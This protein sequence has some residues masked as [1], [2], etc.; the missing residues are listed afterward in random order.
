MDNN[1]ANNEQKQ[2][3]PT[4][5]LGID[6]AI[7]LS[8]T[9][10]DKS[11]LSNKRDV[12]Y[13]LACYGCMFD[14]IYAT[15]PDPILKKYHCF[16]MPEPNKLDLYE[17]AYTMVTLSDDTE[18]KKSWFI[19]FAYVIISNAPHDPE[20]FDKLREILHTEEVFKAVLQSRYSVYILPTQEE[21]AAQG[22][23]QLLLQWY[24]PYLNYCAER[25]GNGV[26]REVNECKRLLALG[27][28]N[29]ALIR[30][31]RLITAFPDDLNAAV[32]D[33]AARVSLSSATDEASRK[34]LLTETLEIIDDYLPY[35]QN[36][37]F[38]YYR[39]LTLLGL[40]DAVG[41]RREFEECLAA[42]PKFELAKLMIA[43]LDKYEN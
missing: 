31:E 14:D 36:Q 39:G 2:A 21:L 43:G 28:F 16:C 19:A 38:R 30:A 34:Q 37:Y 33:V 15:D 3:S 40:M 26:T 8:Y 25:D 12:I 29:D 1:S 27:N 7:K 13:S 9:A 6:Y 32:T 42:D 18:L 17:L 35:A 22:A 4:H 23:S 41:A 5:T 20:L 24:T 10:V 11:E